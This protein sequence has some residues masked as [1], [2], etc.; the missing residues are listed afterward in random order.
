MQCPQCNWQN[1]ASYTHCFSCAAALMPAAAAPAPA[2]PRP[3]AAPPAPSANA[4]V[5]AG[6][7]ARLGATVVDTVVMGVS[8][9]A[10]FA[11][12]I[13]GH[14]A[15]YGGTWPL[16]SAIGVAMLGLLVPA[17]MDAWGRGSPGKQIFKMR[18]V[19]ASGERPGIVR[20]SLRHVLKFAFNLGLPLLFHKLQS[21]MFGERS[22]HNWATGAYVVSTQASDA[23]VLD[24]IRQP[25]R[26]TA[27]LKGLVLSVAGVVAL[28]VLALVASALLQDGSERASPARDAVRRLHGA[29]QPV[30]QLVQ[31]HYQRTGAFPADAQAIGL[32]ALPPGFSAI[33]IHP[34]NGVVRLTIADVPEAP[35]L[36]GRHLVYTPVLRTRKQQTQIGKWQCGSDDIPRADRTL[37][38][39]HEATGAAR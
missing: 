13:A 6:F 5:F 26:S 39:R 25:T 34:A 2:S 32:G 22:L 12:W 16:L 20:A 14:Q 36:A 27:F 24:A 23:A 28:A 21:L 19:T 29:A 4:E 33:A 1:P 8:A 35:G 10:L 11:A 18:V 7:F 38:C 30:T 3:A 15:L 17:A 37:T 9:A 31:N